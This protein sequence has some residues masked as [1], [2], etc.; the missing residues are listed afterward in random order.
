MRNPYLSKSEVAYIHKL[1]VNK[2]REKKSLETT[3]NIKTAETS[4][5]NKSMETSPNNARDESP[6][7]IRGREECNTSLVVHKCADRNISSNSIAVQMKKAQKCG[8]KCN[9]VT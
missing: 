8:A 4:A 5:H 3:P 2:P 6:N 1:L 9:G 7:K